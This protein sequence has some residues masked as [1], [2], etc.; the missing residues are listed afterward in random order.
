MGKRV[1]VYAH[2]TD[3]TREQPLAMVT[4]VGY[5][6]HRRLR[7]AD[8]HGAERTLAQALSAALHDHNVIALL[9]NGEEVRGPV[10]KAPA[11]DPL[12]EVQVASG[13]ER[14][15][16]DVAWAVLVVAALR[17]HG[18]QGIPLSYP[19]PGPC[20]PIVRGAPYKMGRRGC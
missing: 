4:G 3:P 17:R 1:A 15:L 19:E 12:P 14:Q 13:P 11:N 7:R 16:N 10:W 20:G 5:I 2:D 9:S 6:L 8:A 18:F